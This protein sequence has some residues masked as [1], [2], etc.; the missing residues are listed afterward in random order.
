MSTVNL[1]P[2]NMKGCEE[3]FHMKERTALTDMVKVFYIFQILQKHYHLTTCMHAW[4]CPTLCNPMDCSPPSS[5]V[6]EIFQARIQEWVTI[7]YSRGSSRSR[8]QTCISF[9]SCIG[10]QILLPPCTTCDASANPRRFKFLGLHKGNIPT[11]NSEKEREVLSS[12]NL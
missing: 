10:R 9:I 4:L 12:P 2:P 1:T 6:H 11:Q 8:N 3:E 5:S 7:S